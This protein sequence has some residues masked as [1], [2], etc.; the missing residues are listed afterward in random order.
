MRSES[1]D[2]LFS[3]PELFSDSE[4]RLLFH[5]CD[6]DPSG[7]GTG[8][9]PLRSA[10]FASATGKTETAV[11]LLLKRLRRRGAVCEEHRDGAIGLVLTV[12]HVRPKPSIKG[13]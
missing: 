13:R 4:F 12:E 11:L 1:I 2:A 10:E 5:L 9:K 7:D 6:S 3:R 8:W